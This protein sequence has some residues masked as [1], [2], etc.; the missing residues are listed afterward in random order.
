MLEART[1]PDIAR[2]GAAQFGD[3]PALTRAAAAGGG[4]L[5]YIELWTRVRGGAAAL[6][7]ARLR[8]GEAV[9]LALTAQPAWAAA[10][11][12][13]LEAG[14]VAVPLPSTTR[15]DSL[16]AL[17]KHVRARAVIAEGEAAAALGAAGLRVIPLAQ[18]L[19][20]APGAGSSVRPDPGDRALLVPTSGST[21]APRVVELTH[22]NVL[23]DIAALREVR[24]AA[25]GDAF[26]SMLPPTHLFELVCGTLG[27]LG[28]GARVVHPGTLL[29]NRLVAALREERITHALAVPALLSALLAEVWD[30][31]ACGTQDGRRPGTSEMPALAHRLAAES[32]PAGL[33]RVRAAV[34]ERIGP[35]FRKLIVGGAALD[36]SWGDLCGVVD[37]DLD[38]GYGLTEASPVVA[39]GA[40][41]AC[42][43]DSVGR[44]LPGLEV[45]IARDGEILVRGPT[46]MRGYFRDTERSAAAL[47]DGWLRTGDRGR[48]DEDGHLFVTGRLKEAMVAATGETVHPEE[49]EPWYASPLFAEWCVVPVPAADGNDVATLVVVAHPHTS[50]T[51]LAAEWARLRAAAPSR[52]RVTRLVRAQ[53]PLPRTETGKLRR[54]A[55]GEAIAR[56]EPA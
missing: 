28:C 37:V 2:L 12:A 49:A 14:L 8:P 41:R 51:D 40:A 34:R 25:P 39:L 18:L 48:L 36:P 29:P 43:R 3:T 45:R 46:V 15:P 47:A 44:P 16:L 50:E 42:P 31:V 53:R 33:D 54:R 20:G 13:I 30:A 6:H 35:T 24:G 5:S 7:A 52:V 23:A 26:L 27:P 11:L 56:G 32:T 4:G 17:A 9:V 19:G 1:L 22:T 21:G 38:V 10:L 55:L